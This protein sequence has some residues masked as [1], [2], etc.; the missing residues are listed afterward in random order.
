MWDGFFYATTNHDPIIYEGGVSVK[1]VVLNA[2]PATIKVIA[3]DSPDSWG[4]RPY[5]S[6]ELRAGNIRSVSG[7]LIRV[8]LDPEA[9]PPQFAAVGWRFVA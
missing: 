6:T 9:P 8:Q 4:G 1:V 2:G 3:W 7:T 5:V